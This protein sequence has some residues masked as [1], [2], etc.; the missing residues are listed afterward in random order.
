MGLTAASLGCVCRTRADG[1]PSR[2][3]RSGHGPQGLRLGC[4]VEVSLA[5][6]GPSLSQVRRGHWVRCG[7]WRGPRSI[8]L[9]VPGEDAL[10]GSLGGARG[11]CLSPGAA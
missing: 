8:R 5:R 11:L 6:A 1:I 9:K 10:K 2:R 7:L 3:L 4:G